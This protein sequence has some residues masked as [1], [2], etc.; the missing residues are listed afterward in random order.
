MHSTSNMSSNVIHLFSLQRPEVDSI[1]EFDLHIIAEEI[2]LPRNVPNCVSHRLWGSISNIIS[3]A[4]QH[5]RSL[6]HCIGFTPGTQRYYCQLLNM[7]R[8]SRPKLESSTLCSYRQK[9]VL[10]CKSAAKCPMSL[11]KPNIGS[12][13]HQCPLVADPT[14]NYVIRFWFLNSCFMCRALQRG[15]SERGSWGSIATNRCV[16]KLIS[17]RCEIHRGSD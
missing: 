17:A 8:I 2:N 13:S 1:I 12:P 6:I 9:H 14:I 4:R 3:A 7:Y 16:A 11:A 10:Y 15:S 5:E